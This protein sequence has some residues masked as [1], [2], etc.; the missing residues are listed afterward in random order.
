M[1]ELREALFEA[2]LMP[3]WLLS[4][5]NPRNIYP[6]NFFIPLIEAFNSRD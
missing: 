2:L 6:K 5:E 3:N 4:Q 1:K